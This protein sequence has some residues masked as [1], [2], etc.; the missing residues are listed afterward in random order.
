MSDAN[1]LKEELAEVLG[2]LRRYKKPFPAMFGIA[3]G[4]FFTLSRFINRGSRRFFDK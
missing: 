2:G 3:P 4:E 1:A